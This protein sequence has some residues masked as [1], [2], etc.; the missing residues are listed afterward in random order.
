MERKKI[1]FFIVLSLGQNEDCSF[2][3]GVRRGIF[4]FFLGAVRDDVRRGIIGFLYWSASLG[5][6]GRADLYRKPFHSLRALLQIADMT[7]R[8]METTRLDRRSAAKPMHG[9]SSVGSASV[10]G[11][12]WKRDR[13]RFSDQC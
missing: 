10:S 6:K 11:A 3:Y 13:V 7:S 5:F 2:R 12:H 4:G 8:N 1:R 9:T